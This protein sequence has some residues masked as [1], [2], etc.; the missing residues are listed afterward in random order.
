[1]SHNNNTKRIG[2]YCLVRCNSDLRLL[3]KRQVEVRGVSLKQ[4]SQDTG[5]S[6]PRISEYLNHHY[7]DLVRQKG[8]GVPYITQLDLLAL[9]RHL[10]IKISLKFEYE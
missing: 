9:A 10:G 4:I 6:M 8:Q 5:I 2:K 7:L 1:M 3:I